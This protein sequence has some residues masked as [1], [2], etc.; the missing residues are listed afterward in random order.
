[1]FLPAA[2]LPQDPSVSWIQSLNGQVEQT[3]QTRGRW[4]T[5]L[6]EWAAWVTESVEC[7]VKES[8]WSWT[9]SMGVQVMETGHSRAAEA[10]SYHFPSNT[11]SVFPC[12]PSVRVWAIW[13]RNLVKTCA[14]QEREMNERSMS[15]AGGQVA[16]S[17]QIQLKAKEGDRWCWWG[18]KSGSRRLEIIPSCL[19]RG[20]RD[21]WINGIECCHDDDDDD[22]TSIF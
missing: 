1:M 11:L 14:R 13:V 15:R 10:V 4:L 21:K 8:C 6:S 9:F 2:A 12:R 16:A 5:V 20:R 17:P 3:L 22:D 7:R 18:A 19:S